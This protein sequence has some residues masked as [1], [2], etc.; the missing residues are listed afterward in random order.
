MGGYY[1]KLSKRSDVRAAKYFGLAKRVSAMPARRVPSPP[2][3]N[4]TAV[5]WLKKLYGACKKLYGLAFQGEG[6]LLYYV[7]STELGIL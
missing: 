6:I 4:R 1:T 2:R 5:Y 7:P 3:N